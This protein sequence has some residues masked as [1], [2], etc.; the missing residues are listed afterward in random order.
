MSRHRA[1]DK[2]HFVEIFKLLTAIVLGLKDLSSN[3]IY[4]YSISELFDVA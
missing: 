4:D 1:A 3:L 2:G